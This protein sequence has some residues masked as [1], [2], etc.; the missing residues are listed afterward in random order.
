M[1]QFHP[2]EQRDIPHLRAYYARCSYRLCEYAVG[3]K[4]MWRGYLHPAWAEEAGCLIIRNTIEGKM[5]FDYPIP[6]EN[7]DEDAALTAIERYCTAQGI[8]PVLSVVPEVKAPLLTARYPRVEVVNLRVWKDYIYRAQDLISFAGR[9][10]SGQRNHIHR[11]RRE[12]PD[13]FFRPIT[14]EDGALLARFWED[15]GAEFSK[16]DKLAQWELEEA[17]EMFNQLGTGAFIAGGMMDGDRL[18]A[19]C[20]A[21]KCGDTLVDH[22]EKALYSYDGVYPTMVQEFAARYAADC[23]WINREDDA[24]DK[25]LRTSKLQYL[26]AELGS[27]Y[28]FAVGNELELLEAIPA[29]HTDRLT[30]DALTEDDKAAYNALC[31]DDDRNRWWGYDYRTDLQGPLTEDYFLDVTR[32]DFSRRRAVNF[33][34]RLDGQCIGE[35]VLYNCDWRGGMELGCRVA[36]AY[37]GHGY[38]TEAFAA[39]AEWALYRLG[40]AKVVAKCYRENEPSFRMLSSCMR[41]VG[42][43]DTFFYFEK[44]V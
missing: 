23:L 19:V 25:G 20:L 12:H 41:K 27:K 5:Q 28:H 11:F 2:L 22:I 26:P 43:D 7:G 3:T 39:V 34:L 36:P 38:G 32:E 15:Y 24:R 40:L 33:A 31:L 35:A 6:G 10:Y 8:Q 13:A 29:L 37:A 4:Y 17:R 18:I 9:H 30:L 1:L 44:T 42:E 21:E 16:E 14:E